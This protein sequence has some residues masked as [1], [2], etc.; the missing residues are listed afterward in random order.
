MIAEMVVGA[1]MLWGGMF[2]VWLVI[3]FVNGK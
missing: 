2:L 1:V 3:S